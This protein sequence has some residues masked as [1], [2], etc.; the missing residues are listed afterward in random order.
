MWGNGEQACLT[1]SI[2]T[3]QSVQILILGSVFVSSITVRSGIGG[4]SSNPDQIRL[5]STNTLR[6]D[7]SLAMG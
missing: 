5:C 3:E 1:K 7:L 6:I 4:P 2:T